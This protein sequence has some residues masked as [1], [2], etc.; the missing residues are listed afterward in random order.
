MEEKNIKQENPLGYAPLGGLMRKFAIP[1]IISM[2]VNSLYNMTD[3]I[4]IGH[5]IGML[6]NAATNVAFPVT[7]L[8]IAFAQLI[9]VGTAANFNISLGAKKEKDAKK[10]IGTGLTMTG[11]IGLL[12]LVFVLIFKTPL[13]KV[14]GATENVLPLAEMYLGITA[15]GLP[16]LLFTNTA[17]TII[18]A[19]GSPSFSMT[20]TVSG[21]VLNVFLDWLFLFVFRWGIEGAALAT[22]ISQ[23]VSFALCICYF[24]KFRT[25]P[26]TRDMLGVQKDYAVRIAKLGISNFLNHTI[27]MAVAI[28]LNNSLAYYGAM[29]VYGKDIPLAVS[30]VAT[31][32][33]SI[34]VAF[35][36][37]LAHGCQPIL[38]FNIGA[39]NYG[40]VKATYKMA[41][42]IGMCFSVAAFLL[43]QFFP[44]EV[45]SI[46]GAGEPLY[47]EFAERYL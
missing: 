32:L 37:G 43:F 45:I 35:V 15:I 20:C 2:L 24:P 25:F 47:Y 12:F 36:V 42:K 4:F 11:I 16:F 10:Y 29:T 22:A 26:I 31:K 27:M 7:M 30:G 28:V 23:F 34:M 46:F 17:S 44:R 21:E 39:K 38:G 13:L 41:V 19:D 6:G 1:S 14:C 9:G 40:R 33:N 3:Q 8:L 18:R 5:K